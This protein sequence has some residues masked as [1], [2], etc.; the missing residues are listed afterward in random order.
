[1]PADWSSAV[2]GSGTG[3]NMLFTMLPSVVAALAAIWQLVCT[4][5]EQDAST[6]STTVTGITS[7]LTTEIEEVL[8]VRG[9]GG[10]PLLNFTISSVM[11]LPRT[12]GSVRSGPRLPL[13]NL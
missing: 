8:K 5:D 10:F 9:M 4:E 2:E 13:S 6:L 7:P 1:M 11:R 12:A 3:T